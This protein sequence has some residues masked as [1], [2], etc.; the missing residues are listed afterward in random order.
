MRVPIVLTLALAGCQS[1]PPPKA[2]PTPPAVVQ[3]ISDELQLA[4]V[5]L[6]PKAEERLGITTTAARR[7]AVT[8]RR[9]YPG[10]V[11]VPP[12]NLATLLA[13]VA[14]QVTAQGPL[15]VGAAVREGQPLL[16]IAP[17]V[18]ENYVLGPTQSNALQ[19]S[20]L[21]V[22]QT[23]QAILTRINNAKVELDASRI[24]LK[25]AEELFKQQVGSRKR[26]DDARARE[27]LAVQ[28]LQSAQREQ[29]TVNRVTHETVSRPPTPVTAA[30][31]MTGTVSNVRVAAGQAVTVG[32]PLLEVTDLRTVWVRVRLPQSEVRDIVR[33]EPA[34]VTLATGEFQ[35]RPARGQRSGDQLTNTQDLYYEL[36]RAPANPDQRVEVSLPLR[37]AGQH[38]VVPTAALLYDVYGGA[39]VYT[40]SAAQTYR[41]VRVLVA[42]TTHQGQAVLT[43]GPPVGTPVVVHGAAELFGV[44]FGND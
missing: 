36:D 20:R 35:A 42:Y 2:H 38:L 16:S 29:Q 32:Q 28:N 40:R 33:T 15:T 13:P 21:T 10:I 25:R 18:V 24:D 17:L 39:W 7:Q 30:A 43:E 14:G 26:V 9:P 34:A 8:N 12:Q 5:R 27:Q 44:E 31:P 1:A 11:V 22:E 4:S 19:A 37:S 41:R 6:T 23:A 3:Q